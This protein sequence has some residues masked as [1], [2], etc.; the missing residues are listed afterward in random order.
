MLKHHVNRIICCFV[1]HGFV[2]YAIRL[3]TSRRS[4]E[5]SA[6]P[7]S[8]CITSSASQQLQEANCFCRGWIAR[9]CPN[10]SGFQKCPQRGDA[11]EVPPASVFPTSVHLYCLYQLDF[12]T[13]P[14]WQRRDQHRVLVVPGIAIWQITRI[15]N[16]SGACF[17]RQ[18]PWLT[19]A[20][21]WGYVLF[22]SNPGLNYS[23]CSAAHLPISIEGRGKSLIY[24]NMAHLEVFVF[25]F[26]FFPTS[27]LYK[28]LHKSRVIF[29]C[30]M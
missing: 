23:S 2:L 6:S 16:Y 26:V 22:A 29:I 15:N 10:I 30:I 7:Q 27:D 20:Q 18:R 12:P 28:K 8:S 4:L 17:S 11:D 9:V 13:G 1:L 21:F 25:I 14:Y 5:I 19:Q 3:W 24:F